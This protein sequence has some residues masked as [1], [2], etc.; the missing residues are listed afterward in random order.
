METINTPPSGI[1]FFYR[2]D[3]LGGAERLDEQTLT[4]LDA[5]A[6]PVWLHCDYTSPGLANW[7]A[8]YFG[9]PPLAIQALFAEDTRP[10][11]IVINDGVLATLRGVNKNPGAAPE[12]LI[13]LRIWADKRCVITARR[14]RFRSTEEVKEQLLQGTGPRTVAELLVE[15]CGRLTG[16]LNQGIDDFEEQADLLEEQPMEEENRALR[17]GLSELR[18][19]IAHIRRY[20]SPQ[21]DA[22]AQLAMCNLPFLD[23]Q[24]R[25][26]FTEI[27]NHL[28][29]HVEDLDILRERVTIVQ[30]EL[31]GQLAEQM[32]IR[33]YVLNLVAAIFL[34][35]SFLTGLF[36]IN[37]GGIPGSNSPVA[38]FL[39][40]GTLLVIAVLLILLFRRRRW[41]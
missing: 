18:R 9:L 20:V 38:F 30:E 2:L 1:L 39:F 22:L 29:R 24:S 34:P 37:V 15:L 23:D 40:C 13:S 14:Y 16:Y 32:N 33:M 26:K 4:R 19:Q 5:G 25:A 7:V 28:Q 6:A 11:T 17:E 27:N 35:L 41:F 10:R 21:R 8:N 3:G 31:Q 36:G 12:E